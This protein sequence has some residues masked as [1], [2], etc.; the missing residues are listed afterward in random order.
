MTSNIE[1]SLINENNNSDSS[2]YLNDDVKFLS[3]N[4]RRKKWICKSKRWIF[5]LSCLC[6]LL[7]IALII[8]FIKYRLKKYSNDEC[9]SSLSLYSTY[10]NLNS[11]N[12]SD[13]CLDDYDDIFY[14][15]YLGN[16]TWNSSRLPYHLK[17]YFYKIDLRIN[18]YNRVFHGNTTIKFECLKTI[19]FVVIHADTNLA[20]QALKAA[21]KNQSNNNS[22]NYIPKLY[23]IKEEENLSNGTS[24][25][26]SVK[27]KRE[28]EI[29]S[30][31][32]NKFFSYFVMDLAHNETFRRNRKYMI[33]FENFTSNIT[34][35]LK[36]IYYSSY[37]K[38]NQNRSIVV[39][40]LQPLEARKVFP[41]FD[42]P[43]MK[44]YFSISIEHHKGK[45]FFHFFI[46][47]PLL[48]GWTQIC[49]ILS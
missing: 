38:N 12:N 1:T 40:Q 4:N 41:S 29:K 39:S 33:H 8:C 25:S 18:V 36:G 20:F 43:I 16:K 9:C 10:S 23:E 47:R 17:P 2:A 46:Y 5:A 35:N 13:H 19:P 15:Y 45:I 48:T 7:L 26:L 27:F 14:D 6:I 31:S 3:S 21:A 34:N 42:E 44:A 24:Q 32:Y 22:S 49:I 37:T 30:I 11:K 28:L